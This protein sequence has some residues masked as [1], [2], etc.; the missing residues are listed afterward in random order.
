MTALAIMQSVRLVFSLALLF[1]HVYCTVCLLQVFKLILNT[2]LCIH[3][4]TLLVQA[5]HRVAWKHME[6][7]PRVWGEGIYN[8]TEAEVVCCTQQFWCY[9]YFFCCS[10]LP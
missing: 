7:R 1:T 2:H 5:N 3:D 9:S 10:D 4:P 6:C 8:S